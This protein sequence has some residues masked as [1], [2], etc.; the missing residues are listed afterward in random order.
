MVSVGCG[1]MTSDKERYSMSQG[2][3]YNH[4][5]NYCPLSEKASLAASPFFVNSGGSF[6]VEVAP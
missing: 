5:S 1:I 6:C 2:F 4:I 3:F